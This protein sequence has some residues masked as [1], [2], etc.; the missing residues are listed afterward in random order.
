MVEEAMHVSEVPVL[1]IHSY[2]YPENK[3]MYRCPAMFVINTEEDY[4]PKVKNVTSYREETRYGLH[5]ECKDCPLHTSPK[6]EATY[7]DA[8]FY[9]FKYCTHTRLDRPVKPKDVMRQR[10]FLLKPLAHGNGGICGFEVMEEFRTLAQGLK[11]KPRWRE[12]RSP[13]DWNEILNSPRLCLSK[14]Y[15]DCLF[16][17]D[18]EEE[19]WGEHE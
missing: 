10:A 12:E 9:K 2:R 15:N 17:F 8:H 18:W 7:K 5:G 6:N 3:F 13:Y 11:S 19:K 16:I 1:K 14:D 4:G